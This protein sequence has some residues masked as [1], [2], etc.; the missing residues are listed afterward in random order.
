MGKMLCFLFEV[1]EELIVSLVVFALGLGKTM[2][3]IRPR[4]LTSVAIVC[5]YLE[6]TNTIQ[7]VLL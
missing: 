2:V 5:D 3:L 1:I 7:L 4:V 6:L